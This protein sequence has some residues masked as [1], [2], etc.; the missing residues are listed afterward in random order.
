MTLARLLCAS[1]LE[2]GQKDEGKLEEK[3]IDPNQFFNNANNLP[4]GTVIHI[5]FACK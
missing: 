4:D 3:L 5:N 1:K 2:R